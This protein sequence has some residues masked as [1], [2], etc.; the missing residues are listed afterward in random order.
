MQAGVDSASGVGR[1]VHQSNR[2]RGRHIK[3]TVARELSSGVPNGTPDDDAPVAPRRL[4]VV[5][6]D[7]KEYPRR[8]RPVSSQ[9]SEPDGREL[10]RICEQGCE[11]SPRPETTASRGSSRRGSTT[12]L[13]TPSSLPGYRTAAAA[14]RYGATWTMR[15]RSCR[16]SDKSFTTPSATPPSSPSHP[17]PASTASPRHGGGPCLHSPCRWALVPPFSRCTRPPE[18]ER[19]HV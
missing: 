18:R 11:G 13:A 6:S 10:V 14:G 19:H 7:G 2:H 4:T 8:P 16:P 17:G 3:S 5:G 9:A 12:L 15:S 1:H